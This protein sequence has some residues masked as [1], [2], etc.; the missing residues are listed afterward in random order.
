MPEFYISYSAFKLKITKLLTGIFYARQSTNLVKDT[1]FEKGKKDC[2]NRFQTEIPNVFI[3]GLYDFACGQLTDKT[4][5]E[6]SA[7]PVS[8]TVKDRLKTCLPILKG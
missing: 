8:S 4:P 6:V 3:Y 7:A 1:S 2:P 5:S